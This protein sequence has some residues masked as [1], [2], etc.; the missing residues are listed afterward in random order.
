MQNVSG[1]G[2]GLQES[3][4]HSDGRILATLCVQTTMAAMRRIG[5]GS[6][7]GAN[8]LAIFRQRIF[9]E[10]MASTLWKDSLEYSVELS[11]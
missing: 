6:Q 2:R 7:G 8:T 3:P 10:W 5:V 4:T 1:R 9:D 11:V